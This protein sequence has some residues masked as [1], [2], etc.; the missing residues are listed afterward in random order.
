MPK[1]TLND[2]GGLRVPARPAARSPRTVALHSLR[3]RLRDRRGERESAWRDGISWPLRSTRLASRGRVGVPA[4]QHVVGRP[5]H[6]GVPKLGVDMATT[7]LV[8]PR[9]A[10]LGPQRRHT[11]VRA[12]PRKL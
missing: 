7:H 1:L 12:G 3:N 11:Y 8:L 5:R 4:D 9:L 10:M 6:R 2:C